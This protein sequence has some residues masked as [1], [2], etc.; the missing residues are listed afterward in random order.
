VFDPVTFLFRPQNVGHAET[1]GIETYLEIEP[2][3]WLLLYANHT[4][5]HAIDTDAHHELPR[6]PRHRFNAGLQATP[7]ERVSVFVQGTTV[8][9][10]LEGVTQGYNPGWYRVDV[11]GTVRLADRLGVLQKLELTVRMENITDTRYD[12]VQGFRAPGF[13]GLIGLRAAFQ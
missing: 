2:L 10:Q 4:Y 9:R 12:E 3:D 1:Q 7:H 6:F 13:N 11:G 5:T 8:T